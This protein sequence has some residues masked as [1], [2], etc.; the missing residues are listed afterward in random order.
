MVAWMNQEAVDRTL[1]TGRATFYSRS[2]GR[3]WQKGESSGNTLQVRWIRADCDADTL[4]LGVD[5]VGP[6]CHT[7]AQNCFIETLGEPTDRPS[8]LQSEPITPFLQRLE[9]TIADREAST[10]QKSYTKSLLEA[11]A[12]R[13]SAKV[14]EE[15]GELCAA[16]ADESPER[17]ASEAADLL[18][19]VMV[20]LRHRRVPLRSVIEVLEGRFGTSGHQEKANRR[21]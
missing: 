1:E 15:S 16:L 14:E 3:L 19:H 11:G 4:L 17:V 20:G 10:G 6:S 12:T 5:P 7:G 2:R 8:G 21:R 18:F 9:A 13:I